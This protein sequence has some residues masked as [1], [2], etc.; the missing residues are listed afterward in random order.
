VRACIVGGGLAGSL[1]AWRLAGLVSRDW[2]IDLVLG[3]APGADATS[4]SGGAV[5]AYERHPEQRLLAIASLQELLASPTLRRWADYREA[6]SVY[7]RETAAGVEA[8][9]AEIEAE[10]AGSARV[11]S[12]AELNGLGWADL[13]DGVVGVA[14]RSA[15]YTSPDRLRQAALADGT[16]RRRVTMTEAGVG[17]ITPDR[18]GGVEC[19]VASR[20]RGYDIVVVAAGAWTGALLRASG[21]PA[22][23]YRTKSIQY[24]VYRADGFRPTPFVDEV[25]GLYGRPTAEGGLLLGLPTDHW[26]VD[27]DRAPVTPALHDSAARLAGGRFPALRIGPVIRR[28]GSADCYAGEPVLALR[29]VG[30]TDQLFTFTG[31]AGGSVKTVLA[32]SHRAATQL[33]EFRQP[34]V[35]TSL[36]HRKGQR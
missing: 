29:P 24:S 13:P 14:E 26:E 33:A 4:A 28:V 23:G 31:G 9:V 32:A 11:V 25:T 6:G 12:P 7:L 16:V 15:G 18:P 10:L 8:E 5:R 3:H 27:P 19:T 17:A 1:L 2:E 30:D 20:V 34:A 35:L 36:G 21:L 22:D